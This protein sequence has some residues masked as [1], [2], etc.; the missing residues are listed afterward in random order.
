MAGPGGC[1][2]PHGEAWGL[3]LGGYRSPI[4]RIISGEADRLP[5]GLFPKRGGSSLGEEE[6]RI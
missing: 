6:G 3:D 4:L 2:I 5:V 1:R